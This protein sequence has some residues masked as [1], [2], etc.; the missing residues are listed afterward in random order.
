MVRYLLIRT[1]LTLLTFWLIVTVVFFLMRLAPGGPFDGERRLPPEV[2]TNLRAAYNLDKSLPQQYIDYLRML[3][4]G[5]LGPSFR[6]KDFS[7]NELVATGLPV[8]LTIGGLALI[9]ATTVGIAVGLKAGLSPG[10]RK[11][12]ALMGLTNVGIAL[13]TI[14]VAPL[15]VL[16]FGVTLGWLPT[17][18][19]GSFSHY[20]LPPIALALPFTAAIAR[21]TR[22]SV[23]E[24]LSEPH[25]K[26]ARAKG[27]TERLIIRRHIFPIALLPVV[28]Y[29]GPAATS[30]LTGSVVIEQVFE[31]PGIGR[32]FVQG[33]LN[34]DYTLVMGVVVVYA[35]L[36]LM[37]NLLVDLA[38]ARMDP[39]IR[40]QE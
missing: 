26:T 30:L 36:I 15:L 35:A 11:D 21:L 6:Q 37:F 33:A 38:Y 5:D 3:G 17:G 2:E 27:L 22:G 13:P 25:L 19:V 34:R 24:T 28:S 12:I 10:S 18:G 29:L 4:R 7:V 14:I 40:L 20:I 8:S 16:V 31:L 9:I 1:G 32:Y 39:R 23:V